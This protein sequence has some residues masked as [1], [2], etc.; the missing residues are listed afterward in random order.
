[1]KIPYVLLLGLSSVAVGQQ[2]PGSNA[3]SPGAAAPRVFLAASDVDARVVQADAAAKAAVPFDAA[4]ATPALV[5]AREQY[6]YDYL[7]KAGAAL[8]AGPFRA[9]LDFHIMPRVGNGFRTHHNEA[10]LLLV[11]KGTG[12]LSVGG[13]LVDARQVETDEFHNVQFQAPSAKGAVSH[14]MGA[15]SVILLPPDIVHGQTRVDAGGTVTMDLRLPYAPQ[16]ATSDGSLARAF[17]SRQDIERRL[18]AADAKAAGEW[19]HSDH[20]DAT[21]ERLENAALNEGGPLLE[22]GPFRAVIDCQVAAVK[23]PYRQQPHAAQLEV[24]LEGAGTFNVGGTAYAVTRGDILLVPPGSQY[25][26]TQ[27]HLDR[28]VMLSMTLPLPDAPAAH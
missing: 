28:V 13:T 19:A 6:E 11:L 18:A 17:L 15:G 16:T 14:E 7:Q 3:S 2:P 22:S 20:T 4:S 10:E 26:L 24:I 9:F 8:Q 27:V 5:S 25:A 21:R 12:A 23:H 1:M